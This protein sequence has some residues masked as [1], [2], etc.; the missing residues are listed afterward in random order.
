M[1]KIP[2]EFDYFFIQLK[3]FIKVFLIHRSLLIKEVFLRA[4]T[5][6]RKQLMQDIPS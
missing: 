4:T 6:G 3:Q 5:I 1:S 2:P